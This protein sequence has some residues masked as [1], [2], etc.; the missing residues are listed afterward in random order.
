MTTQGNDFI[1]DGKKTK[2]YSGA[3]HYFRVPRERW[4]DSINK[5][6]LM[7]LNTIE[8]YVAWNVH[9]T[10]KGE[11]N[12]EG[13]YDLCAFLDEIKKA[14]MYAIVR[15]GPY[16]CA[17]WD[18][19]GFPYWLLQDD[20]IRLR[21]MDKLYINELSRWYEKLVPMLLPYTIENGGSIVAVQ[22]EN[23]YGSYGNDKEYLKW[24]MEKM[25]NLGLNTFYFTSD[26]PGDF[27]L[28]GGTLPDVLKIVNFGSNA[29]KADK[30]L[31][32][33]QPDKPF[34]CGEFWDGWF[35]AWGSPDCFHART[36]EDCVKELEKILKMGG[37]FNLYMFH[38]GTNFGFMAGANCGEKYTPD[39]TSY[40]YGAPLDESGNITSKY[41]LMRECMKKYTNVPNEE[42]PKPS[43][44]NNYGTHRC[45]GSVTLFDSLDNISEKINSPCPYNMERLG[46]GYGYILY[47]TKIT[48]PRN[49]MP[50]VLQEV[51]DRAQ[52]FADE[53]FIGI[54]DRNN[55][56]E[57][58]MNVSKKGVN[59]DVLV[60]NL[61]RVNYGPMLKDK[62]G[63]TEGI[64]HGQQYLFGYDIYCLPMDNLDKLKFNKEKLHKHN[65][66]YH[67]EVKVDEC[68]DTYL[69]MSDWGKGF[70]TLNGIN[71]GRY[72][73]I[74]PQTKLFIPASF[75]RQ[76]T[77][78]IIVFEEYKACDKIKFTV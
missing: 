43:I 55:N 74:G 14:G 51:R 32:K 27:M 21:C 36:D 7:G 16:I 5:A 75:L 52:V 57:L 60:E 15:P 63:I 69:D 3:I 40:D 41:L 48:G 46:Q 34:M 12:F 23:E 59:L 49:D 9:E 13:M 37:S 66:F 45:D 70:V 35:N 64:R 39:T 2:I 20:N 50:I 62:K 38:G 29:D 26:G 76:G 4:A 31:R 61:A 8:T 6:R 25:I 58:S 65:A 28:Q 24:C 42:L 53:K 67:F 47:R 54:V 18:F 56:Q 19:G 77:N 78:E 17:E 10:K 11:Y 30:I 71:L 1:I 68:C 73:D 33:Y 44:K 22:V 72:W